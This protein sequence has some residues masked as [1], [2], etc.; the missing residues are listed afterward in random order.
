MVAFGPVTTSF[1]HHRHQ[2][3]LKGQEGKQGKPPLVRRKALNTANFFACHYRPEVQDLDGNPPCPGS[4]SAK[5]EDVE[6]EE[7]EELEEEDDDSLAGKSQEDTVSPT[8]EPQGVYE[9][10]EDEEPPNLTMDFDHTR[11]WAWP[12]ARGWCSKVGVAGCQGVVPKG[13]R[14]RVRGDGLGERT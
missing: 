8:P 7:E 12:G 4:A 3:F 2:F 1:S 11:R 13:G 6:E 10:E 9:D 5:Q 14:G